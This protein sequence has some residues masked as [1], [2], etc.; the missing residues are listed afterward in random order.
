MSKLITTLLLSG[1][2]FGLV[3]SVP[4]VSAQTGAA[5]NQTK[6]VP[7]GIVD[8]T[9]DLPL[10]SVLLLA[11]KNNLDITFAKMQ[12]DVAETDIQ[13]EEGAV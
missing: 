11:L 5:D 10:E 6:A 2:V 8:N 4:W 1:I 7:L 13:R 12:P 9:V 3:G